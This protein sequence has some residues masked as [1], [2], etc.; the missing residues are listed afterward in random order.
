VISPHH[1][2]L[3]QPLNQA[4]PQRRPFP[5]QDQDWASPD[6]KDKSIGVTP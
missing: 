5:G 2:Q 6:F 3:E 4:E 1:D